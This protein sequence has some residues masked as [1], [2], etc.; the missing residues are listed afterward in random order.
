LER[1]G[2]NKS[3]FVALT[4]GGALNC[5]VKDE[6]VDDDYLLDFWEL[7]SKNKVKSKKANVNNNSLSLLTLKKLENNSSQSGSSLL[8]ALDEL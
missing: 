8:D 2:V 4:A 1:S 7:Y 5:L 6:E 3:L